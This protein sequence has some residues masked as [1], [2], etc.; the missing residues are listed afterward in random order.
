MELIIYVHTC[1]CMYVCVCVL[2]ILLDTYVPV[3]ILYLL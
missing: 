3:V 2:K 1:M